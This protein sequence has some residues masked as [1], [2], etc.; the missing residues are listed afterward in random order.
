MNTIKIKCPTCGKVLTL[1][2]APGINSKPF[3]CPG[4][5]EKHI[6]GNCP[7]PIVK[8]KPAITSEE[9]QYNGAS[10]AN[11]GGEET[12]FG[13][14]LSHHSNSEETQIVSSTVA[15]LGCIVDS[16]G[17]QYALA[18]GINTVGRKA[19]SSPATVQIAVD[20]RYMSRNHAIIEVQNAGGQI[21]HILKN[22]AN[23]N[24]SYLN[25][26]LLADGDQMILNNGD[27]IKL[28]MTTLTFKK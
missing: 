24:P 23:K 2:D 3:I 20:D 10:M 1:Q 7:R 13:S 8:P 12:Q 19:S 4:C 17:H 26:Q 22:G 14:S 28:G 6:V 21:I 11:T 5:K 25:D 18:I 27:R 15:K 9:T 16:L